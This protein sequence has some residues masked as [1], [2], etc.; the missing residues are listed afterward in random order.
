MEEGPNAA[1]TILTMNRD[2]EKIENEMWLNISLVCPL[3]NQEEN[4]CFIFVFLNPL[5]KSRDQKE[6]KLYRYELE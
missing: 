2:L 5:Q 6:R 3:G 4:T 1:D